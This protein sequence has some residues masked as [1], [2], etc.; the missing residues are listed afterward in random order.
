MVDRQHYAENSRKAY[1]RSEILPASRGMIVDRHEEPL[2]KSIP[3]SSVFVD[4]NRRSLLRRKLFRHWVC[5][6]SFPV[7]RHAPVVGA[8][9][10]RPFKN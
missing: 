1:H 3:V 2:A 7:S 9:P 8:P 6:I 4:K 5:A 10:A